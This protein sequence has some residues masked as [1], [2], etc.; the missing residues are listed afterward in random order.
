[1]DNK[2]ITGTPILHVEA[3]FISAERG[4][5]REILSRTSLKHYIHFS[6]ILKLITFICKQ[7]KRPVAFSVVQ[8]PSSSATSSLQLCLAQP[9]QS[10]SREAPLQVPAADCHRGTKLVP[11]N[12]REL[13]S[14]RGLPCQP[15]SPTLVPNTPT[16]DPPC[17]AQ[18]PSYG[19]GG[20]GQDGPWFSHGVC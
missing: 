12:S 10:F 8:Y 17:S 7:L 2:S 14:G 13:T 15:S 18:G 4:L 1:V 6:F 20:R 16:L 3:S 9:I 19:Q 5:R 11:I